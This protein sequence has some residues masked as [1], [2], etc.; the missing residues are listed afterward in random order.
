MKNI[1]KLFAAT[2]LIMIG[3]LMVGVAHDLIFGH[4]VI[5]VVVTPDAMIIPYEE[6]IDGWAETA[7]LLGIHPDSMTMRQY[8]MP[9]YAQ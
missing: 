7:N 3:V 2:A 5:E 9:K 1:I 4:D 8:A 6:T